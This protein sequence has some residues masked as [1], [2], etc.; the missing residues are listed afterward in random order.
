M[1]RHINVYWLD[2]NK[3]QHKRTLTGPG[4][5]GRFVT[6]ILLNGGEVTG[7]IDKEDDY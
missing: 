3:E 2:K 6:L 1:I 5:A 7:V 4:R